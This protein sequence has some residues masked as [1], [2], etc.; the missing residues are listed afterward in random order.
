MVASSSSSTSLTVISTP[1]PDEFHPVQFRNLY[2]QVSTILDRL[3]RKGKGFEEIG[4]VGIGGSGKTTLALLVFTPIIQWYNW[5]YRIWICLFQKLS[6]DVEFKEMI[7]DMLKQCKAAAV[8][9]SGVEVGVEELLEIL[10]KALKGKRYL[11]VLDGIWD[12]NIDWYFKLKEKLKSLSGDGDGD[13]DGYGHVI[14]TSR[15]PHKAR[16]MVGPHNLYQMQPP[17]SMEQ[18]WR[19]KYGSLLEYLKEYRLKMKDEVLE[20]CDGLPLAMHTLAEVIH[21]QI[22][23]TEYNWKRFVG[24]TLINCEDDARLGNELLLSCCSISYKD[25]IIDVSKVPLLHILNKVTE[26]IKT[27]GSKN[28]IIVW[29]GDAMANQLMQ[30]ITQ[31]VRNA[32]PDSNPSILLLPLG[33]K[34]NI[35]FSLGWENQPPTTLPKDML[36]FLREVITK[37]EK[38]IDSW[39][40]VIKMKS[41]PEGFQLPSTFGLESALEANLQPMEGDKEFHAI[42]W[43]Y[44]IIGLDVEESLQKKDECCCSC[45]FKPWPRNI[46]LPICI[47]TKD[48][49]GEWKEISIPHSTK[50]IVCLNLPC[51]PDR[52]NVKEKYRNFK[53]PFVN[54]GLLEVICFRDAWHGDDFL[55]SKERGECLAQGLRSATPPIFHIFYRAFPSALSESLKALIEV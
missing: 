12:I 31:A 19:F 45:Y 30:L 20:H 15:L 13:G 27:S 39:G 28:T 4:I 5:D 11:M 8:V 55:P 38:D 32:K 35:S 44:F 10:G 25:Y 26:Y 14:I 48:Q 23:G 36:Q 42:F 37:P 47:K 22:L 6:G 29:S 2:E 50:S 3:V 52:P 9:D 21:K 1:N 16:M 43:N 34:A 53:D 24:I 18:A 46:V 54:D 41:I 40:V 7:K 33:S 17:S 51:F 49:E